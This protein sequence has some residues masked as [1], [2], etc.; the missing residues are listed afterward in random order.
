MQ[1]R[2]SNRNRW[3]GLSA[4]AVLAAGSSAQAESTGPTL[5]LDE[6]IARTLA[7]DP[8]A[9]VASAREDEARATRQSATGNYGPRLQADATWFRFNETH[10][11]TAVDPAHLDLSGVPPTLLAGIQPLLVQLAKPIRFRDETVS[12][13][14]LSVVQPITQLYSVHHGRQA[15]KGGEDAAAAQRIQA[16]REATYRATESYYR[17]LAAQRLQEVATEAVTTLSAHL[18][19][20]KQYREAEMLGLD[21]YLAVEVEL[22]NARENLIRAKAQRQLATTAIATLMGWTEPNAFAVAKIPDQ[23]E[24]PAPPALADA[25]QGGLSGRPELAALRAATHAADEQDK[26]AWWQ[27]VPQ[28]SALGRYQHSRGTAMNNPNEWFVGG[29]LSWTAWD[30]GA[31]YFR[32]KAATA[33]GRVARARED[34]ARDSI[35]LEITQRSLAVE[36]ARERL[37]VARLTERQAVEAMRVARMK[38]EQHTIASTAVLDAQARLSRA[39]GNRVNAQ[40]DLILAVAALRL[41]MG[42]G[43]VPTVLPAELTIAQEK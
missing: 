17:L 7:H 26:M 2:R 31:T 36:S 27:L 6:V 19:Q 25:R 43:S 11:V 37:L 41:S 4:L 21:E 38:F 8:R 16:E 35:H 24:P 20:A 9:R 32:A 14:Q 5:A 22:G 12:Q 28:L 34:D 18:E 10:D 13:L 30:W 3:V 40:Y 15:A 1:G 23:A 39:Q 33:Q 29:V 42:E